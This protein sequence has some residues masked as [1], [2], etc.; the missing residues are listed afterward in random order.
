[1]RYIALRQQIVADGKRAGVPFHDKDLQILSERIV[2][3]GTSFIKVTLPLL[4]RA[5]DKGLV[6]GHFI[7]PAN[8]AMRRDS[9]LPRFLYTPLRGVFDDEGT[10]CGEPSPLFVFY[11]RQFL[12]FDAKLISEPSPEQK[13]R[14]VLGFISRQENLRRVSLPLNDPILRRAQWLLG[15]VLRDLDLS[16][17]YP[18]HGPGS[19]AEKFS[20]EERWDFRSWPSKAE[21]V[22]PYVE[23]GTPSMRA[24]LERGI[25]IP[26]LKVMKTRCCLVPKDFRGPRLISAEPTVNQYL[27]QGQMKAIMQFVERH[28]VLSKSI[29]LRD[30][31]HNQEMA[32]NA[33][34]NGLV[35]LDLSD[36]SDTVSV[37]L[38]WYL[39]SH[40]PK[41]RRQLFSTRSDF[42]TYNGQDIKLVAFSPMG[43]ATCFPIETLVFWAL[44]MATLGHVRSLSG[45]PD[46]R[47]SLSY[48]LAVFGDDIIIPEDALSPLISVLL[49]VGC[50]PNMHKTC[51][52]TSFRESCGT[53]W[54][55]GSDVTIIR[56]RRFAYDE[57]KNIS[58]YPVLLELQRKFFLRGLYGTAELCREWAREIYP[59]VTVP[60]SV[61]PHP[62]YNDPAGELSRQHSSLHGVRGIYRSSLIAERFIDSGIG[63]IS[64]DARAYF[65]RQ[66][67][68]SDSYHV[69]I[70][71]SSST[72][73]TLPIRW[74]KAYQRMEFRV[75]I[76]HQPHMNWKSEGY[77][78]L[79]AR[80]S[81][82]S[83]DRFVTRDRK[84]RLTWVYYP[85][86]SG[87]FDPQTR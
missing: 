86:F 36:A 42:M 81:S 83:T 9:R 80:L 23:Y 14:A 47:E 78:R 84:I 13:E 73:A 49:S 54:I 57:E 16:T 27:Q 26:L 79:F 59:V 3:E 34:A 7:C 38:V 10:I 37:A 24:S 46:E 5:L 2:N 41:L 45:H 21:R 48:D 75:P 1:M 39:F 30:Q 63:G 56:N 61:F 77:S 66:D 67:F 32:K 19:V 43:S 82:D 50:S 33:F 69:A 70:G 58:N 85:M 60:L 25:G 71:W 8:F 31:S 20:R 52:A 53:E 12:L 74:N 11:L 28:P 40:L 64:L 18:G 55:N 35:T 29:R 44:S 65:E 68:A 17:I 87:A 22:Y 76:W 4:G 15:S 72:C 6:T 62:P 51:F